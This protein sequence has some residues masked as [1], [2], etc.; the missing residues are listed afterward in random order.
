MF[1]LVQPNGVTDPQKV[2]WG[3]QNDFYFAFNVSGSQ[4][5]VICPIFSAGGN[6][7][8]LIRRLSVAT[9]IRR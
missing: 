3:Y 7:P 9:L 2:L 1:V 6:F 5:S 8:S 4:P